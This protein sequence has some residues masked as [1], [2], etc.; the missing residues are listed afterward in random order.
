[1]QSS[2]LEWKWQVYIARTGKAANLLII[3]S[4]L[5]GEQRTGRLFMRLLTSPRLDPHTW[6]QILPYFDDEAVLFQGAED[7]KTALHHVAQASGR[8]RE[9]MMKLL[10]ARAPAL[11]T[12]RDREGKTPLE[13]VQAMLS[14]Y[15]KPDPSNDILMPMVKS[16]HE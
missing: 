14:P 10:I 1:L 3:V 8:H 2:H 7:G 16:A 5:P 11:R 12:L 15:S 13:A 6:E 4:H 9:F